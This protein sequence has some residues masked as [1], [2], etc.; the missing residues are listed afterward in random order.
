MNQHGETFEDQPP[1]GQYWLCPLYGCK[2][3]L[4]FALPFDLT[5]NPDRV[6]PLWTIGSMAIWTGYDMRAAGLLR[7]YVQAGLE[8]HVAGR[9]RRMQEHLKTHE[10]LDFYSTRA[11][12]FQEAQKKMERIMKLA[13]QIF[14]G[15]AS[16]ERPE[17]GK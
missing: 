3:K 11:E 5:Q 13:D 8:G 2:Y 10:L 1:A 16:Q 14:V 4:L 15:T 17:G 9:E 12:I 6:G 7:S